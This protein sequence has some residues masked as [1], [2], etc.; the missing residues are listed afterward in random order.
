MDLVLRIGIS[1]LVSLLLSLGGILA[2]R[3][4]TGRKS[5]GDRGV[6]DAARPEFSHEALETQWTEIR[7]GLLTLMESAG[8]ERRRLSA[9]VERSAR[10]GAALKAAR[11]GIVTHT[12]RAEGDRRVEQIRR[13]VGVLSEK[14]CSLEEI[15]QQLKL[16]ELE[17]SLYLHA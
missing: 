12:H 7:E 13:A 3:K 17:V 15:S 8:S 9:E 2:Y 11:E 10:L 16:G 14:G 4:R 1:L 5:R 6:A